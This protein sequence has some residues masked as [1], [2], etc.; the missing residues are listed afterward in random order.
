[1]TTTASSRSADHP[2]GPI[3]VLVCTD[4]ASIRK[5]E[6]IS[7][8]LSSFNLGLYEISVLDNGS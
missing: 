2:L 4:D 6:V 1:M 8:Y 7:G 3:D 5:N